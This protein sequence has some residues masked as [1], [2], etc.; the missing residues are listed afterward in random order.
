MDKLT[1]SYR[2]TQLN[3]VENNHPI[4]LRTLKIIG[5]GGQTNWLD[6]TSVEFK[7]IKKILIK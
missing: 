5:M 3:R 4:Y 6:I 7:A 2:T 1:K